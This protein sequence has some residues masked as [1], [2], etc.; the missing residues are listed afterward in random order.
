MPLFSFFPFLHF[1]RWRHEP[2][3]GGKWALVRFP[4]TF[5]ISPLAIALLGPTEA[6]SALPWAGPTARNRIPNLSFVGVP[7]SSASPR[8]R[9]RRGARINPSHL[10][11]LP[12]LRLRGDAHD[13]GPGRRRGEWGRIGRVTRA[14]LYGNGEQGR[15]R[16]S[17]A[18][19]RSSERTGFFPLERGLS[20]LGPL[21][22]LR[23]LS[24][25]QRGV[26][27]GRDRH[28]FW[29]EGPSPSSNV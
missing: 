15:S 20:H 7:T 10:S 11:T 23:V 21:S 3:K 2:Y 25:G 12:P 1:R 5:P 19:A 18:I 4:V 24:L 9:P 17:P 6:V 22:L 8:R 13:G 14:T 28:P 16:T 29:P 26:T 27:R